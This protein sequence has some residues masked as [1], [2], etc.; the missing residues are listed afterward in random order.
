M[1]YSIVGYGVLTNTEYWGFGNR[2]LAEN[3][4]FLIVDQSI[5]YGVSADVDTAHS[6]MSGNDLEFSKVFRY[7]VT[8]SESVTFLNSS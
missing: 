8:M 5:I 7:G 4:F 6:S 1:P 3:M 2:V